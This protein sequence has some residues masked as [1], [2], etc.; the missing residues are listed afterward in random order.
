MATL[1]LFDEKKRVVLKSKVLP[2]I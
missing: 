2:F 1:L